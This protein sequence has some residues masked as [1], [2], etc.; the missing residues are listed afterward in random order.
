METVPFSRDK[1]PTEWGKAT[2]DSLKNRVSVVRM[3]GISRSGTMK[4]SGKAIKQEIV[5]A[6]TDYQR[7][8]GMKRLNNWTISLA[9]IP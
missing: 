5:K 1:V 3:K 6:E 8:I 4:R 2:Y 7:M 9:I